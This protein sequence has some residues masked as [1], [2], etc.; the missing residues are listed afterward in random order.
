MTGLYLL[1]EGTTHILYKPAFCCR[2]QSSIITSFMNP[3][4]IQKESIPKPTN[5]HPPFLSSLPSIPPPTNPSPHIK[6][7]NRTPQL[8]SQA[9]ELPA[10]LLFH[11]CIQK[12]VFDHLEPMSFI[13]G[14][15]IFRRFYENLQPHFVRFLLSPFH[16]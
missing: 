6:P 4:S 5:H 2:K 13:H 14:S 16:H 3:N 11:I 10:W 12:E 1:R 9:L 7:M 8:P 15:T